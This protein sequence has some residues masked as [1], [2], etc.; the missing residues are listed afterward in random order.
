[1]NDFDEIT[2]LGLARLLPN[3]LSTVFKKIILR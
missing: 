1:M 3:L 2:E